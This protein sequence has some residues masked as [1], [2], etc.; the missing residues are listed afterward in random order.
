MRLRELV[1][2]EIQ[3]FSARR[4]LTSCLAFSSDVLWVINC[5]VKAGF[6]DV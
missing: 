6:N 5:K 3:R 2:V 1:F 4:D